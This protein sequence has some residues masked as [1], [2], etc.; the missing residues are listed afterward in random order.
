MSLQNQ[1]TYIKYVNPET[2]E[3]KFI[4][5]NSELLNIDPFKIYIKIIQVLLDK[6]IQS[7]YRTGNINSHKELGLFENNNQNVLINN[8]NLNEKAYNKYQDLI[9]LTFNQITKIVEFLGYSTFKTKRLKEMEDLYQ[10]GK[11]TF[12]F[13]YFKTFQI[14]YSIWINEISEK[15]NPIDLNTISKDKIDSLSKILTILWKFMEKILKDYEINTREIL[16]LLNRN[17]DCI[18]VGEEH[19]FFEFEDPTRIKKLKL[20]HSMEYYINKF[21]N[22]ETKFR[23]I[24]DK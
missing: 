22:I 4:K 12:K 20:Q 8:I 16:I 21:S 18:R 24:V 3:E 10:I 17:D 9:D 15:Y 19:L 5:S 13:E 2:G 11:N 1:D 7:Y 14:F 23:E 6:I